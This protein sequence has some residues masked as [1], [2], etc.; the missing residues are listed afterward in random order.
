LHFQV[1]PEWAEA[2]REAWAELVSTRWL[3]ADAEFTAVSMRNS[4]NQGDGGTHCAGNRSFDHF[5][6]KMVCTY[7]ECITFIF[8]SCSYFIR[9][10]FLFVMQVAEAPPGEEIHDVMVYDMMRRKKPIA[11]APPD[12]APSTMAMPGST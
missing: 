6:G 7:M 4:D 5:K 10:T 11:L 1:V 8:P 2:H 3:R 9:I 12:A